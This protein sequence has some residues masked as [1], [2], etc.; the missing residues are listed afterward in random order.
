[1]RALFPD[2]LKKISSSL[3]KT[4]YK[5]Q[6]RTYGYSE[7]NTDAFRYVPANRGTNICCLCVITYTGLIAYEIRSGAYNFQFFNVFLE[8]ELADYFRTHPEKIRVMENA[9]FHHARDLGKIR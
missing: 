8:R 6:C 9:R 2:I 5:H 3:I 4:G 7:P 1:M